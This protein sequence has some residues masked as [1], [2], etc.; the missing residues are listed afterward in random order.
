MYNGETM[1]RRFTIVGI[2]L[3][4]FVFLS[5]SAHAQ[6]SQYF[7]EIPT[8][9]SGTFD[10]EDEE[11]EAAKEAE[12]FGSEMLDLEPS[13]EG[14]EE[15]DEED[16]ADEFEDEVQN[17]L[18]KFTYEG[19]VIITDTLTDISY[20]EIT[21]QIN[22]EQ[23]VQI[24]NRRFRAEGESEII[25]S[26]VGELAGNEL[27]TCELEV[28]IP[29]SKVSLLL[30]HQETPE[31][32]EEDASSILAGQI[33]VANLKEDWLA[34]CKGNDGSI[35]N[36]RGDQ[37][38]YFKMLIDSTTPELKGFVIEDYDREVEASVDITTDPFIIE[39]ID[40]FE[41]FLLQGSGLVTIEPI[42]L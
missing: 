10:E 19:Q 29:N 36:T 30:R 17:H 1:I 40:A 21:Y 31:T 14:D 15:A 18:L 25:T 22:L 28:Q 4:F 24:L 12:I 13:E 41:E 42:E 38:E 37:E 8:D 33:K 9:F 5:Q 34:N 20:L 16:L 6:A 27:F 26:V 2:S 35:F 32:E 39:D 11:S 3:L 23:E 7:K